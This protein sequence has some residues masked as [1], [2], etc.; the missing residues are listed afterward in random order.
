MQE[1]VYNIQNGT[2]ASGTDWWALISTVIATAAAAFGLY[3]AFQEYKRQGE[4]Q[5]RQGREKRAQQFLDIRKSFRESKSFQNILLHL[6][7][8]R[9]FTSVP[10]NERI[11]FMG[12]FEDMAYLVNSDLMR[13]EVAFYMFGGDAIAAWNNDSFWSQKLRDDKNWSLITDFVKEA[14]A[15][16]AGEIRGELKQL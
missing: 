16:K 11:E 8:D 4:E 14:E 5:K 15:Y 6:Y 1:A 2:T 13:R 7:T 10:L 3:K 9:D 12:L